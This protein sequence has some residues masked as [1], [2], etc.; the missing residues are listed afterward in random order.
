MPTSMRRASNVWRQ[1]PVMPHLTL[2]LRCRQ[3][4]SVTA[5][6]SA[7]PNNERGLLRGFHRREA[8]R[9]L[10][11]VREGAK[12][13]KAHLGTVVG[14]DSGNLVIFLAGKPLVPLK[15]AVTHRSTASKL[16]T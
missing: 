11:V 13:P 2:K 4:T 3:S 9:L 5:S 8:G 15:C 12:E 1:S 14:Q 16:F 6:P 7:A 10:D